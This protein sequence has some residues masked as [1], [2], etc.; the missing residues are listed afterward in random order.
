M[1]L[2]SVVYIHNSASRDAIDL[3]KAYK[4]T[5]CILTGCV[6]L[7]VLGGYKVPVACSCKDLV[8]VVHYEKAAA[9][10]NLVSGLSPAQYIK[11]LLC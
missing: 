7:L 9:I 4:S 1:F 8:M 5:A 6:I 3:L 11:W 10:A 2:R